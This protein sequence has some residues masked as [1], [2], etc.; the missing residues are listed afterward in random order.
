MSK[1]NSEFC[2]LEGNRLYRIFP[3][4][5]AVWPVLGGVVL[6]LLVR[7]WASYSMGI[8]AYFL[9]LYPVMEIVFAVLY[10]VFK[11]KHDQF[12]KQ[13]MQMIQSG[14]QAVGRILQVRRHDSRPD[15]GTNRSA[16]SWYYA[17]I[18]YYDAFRG[19]SVIRWTEDLTVIPYGKGAYA[20]TGSDRYDTWY[21]PK[22]ELHCAVYYLEGGSFLVV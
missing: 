10:R 8:K 19:E 14:Q 1:K 11:S 20:K 13:R 21:Q 22:A 7:D 4:L 16:H 6:I 15:D 2:Y 3:V 12:A 9:T 17:E 18:E 5:L